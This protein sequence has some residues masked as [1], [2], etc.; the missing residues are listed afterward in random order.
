MQNDTIIGDPLFE[1]ALWIGKEKFDKSLCYEIHGTAG[2][3]YN[4]IS[5][6]CVSVN[7]HF[8]PMRNPAAGNIISGIGIRAVGESQSC[9]NVNIQQDQVNAACHT[10]IGNSSELNVGD[11]VIIN[12]I[13]VKQISM[14][15][16]RVSVPNC[17]QLPI[18]MYVKC[19][20]VSGE[21]MTRFE[22]LRG[23]NLR[24]TSHGLIGKWNTGSKQ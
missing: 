16:V 10:S 11:H 14:T 19:D 18:V 12:G 20:N 17:E 23:A 22:V 7:A 8:T 4:L 9:H 6:T 15:K 1:A 13:A 3:Y 24:P 5:D 2:D 21:F